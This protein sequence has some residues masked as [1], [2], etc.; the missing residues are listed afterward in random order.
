MVDIFPEGIVH[1]LDI[2]I[3]VDGSDIYCKDT[4]TQVNTHIFQASSH[5][6]GKLLGLNSF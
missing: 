4:H 5:F 1:F 6:K 2:K 3:S